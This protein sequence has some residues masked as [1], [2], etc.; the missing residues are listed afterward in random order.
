[1]PLDRV[2]GSPAT[3]KVLIV[4]PEPRHRRRLIGLLQSQDDTAV[5][6]VADFA[7]ARRWLK[8]ARPDLLITNLRVEAY[9]GINLALLAD[10]QE[11]TSIVY[12]VAH[13][14]IAARDVQQAGA[15][16]ELLDVLPMVLPAYSLQ[17][18]KERDRRR[19]SPEVS[20]SSSDPLLSSR[21]ERRRQNRLGLV[22][23]D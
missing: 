13:D 22:K 6:A 5:M 14:V 20:H 18:T 10:P 8:D 4:D 3:T 15:F 1:M 21:P 17:V 19:R 16:Y 2:A 23:T 12:S 9:N 11:T 7:T